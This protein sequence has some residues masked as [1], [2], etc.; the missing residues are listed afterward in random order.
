LKHKIIDRASTD[1]LT[2]QA[3]KDIKGEDVEM[4]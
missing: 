3:L 2:E 4:K 1:A